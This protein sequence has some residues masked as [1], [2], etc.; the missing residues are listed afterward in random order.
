MKVNFEY[1]HIGGKKMFQSLEYKEYRRKW[2][3][4]PQSFIVE[5]FP[6]FLDIDITNVC[7][8]S[9][10]FCSRQIIKRKCN[11]F[12]SF[13]TVK[14]VIDEGSQN[15]LYG[16]KFNILAEPLMHPELVNFVKY[17]KDKKLIDVYFN[18]N[19]TLLTK[20]ISRKLIKAKLNR[21]SISFEGY[22]KEIYERYR[23]GANFENVVQNIKTLQKEKI[24]LNS[25]VPKV[26]IQTIS[27][28]DVDIEEYKKYW[29]NIVDEV[30][31][32]KYQ[33]RTEEMKHFKSNWICSQLWQRMGIMVD[34][35]IIPC[36]HDENCLS[37]LGNI[38]QT[39]IKE[40]WNSDKLNLIRKQHKNCDAHLLKSC[41]NCYLRQ[42]EII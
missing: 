13:E 42:S 21:I 38:S 41:N 11:K 9:C 25:K 7:N 18:T 17:A 6:L 34:G 12:M 23:V 2:K 36:N 16:V 32:L 10:L 37:S 8:L 28:P 20:N 3:Q 33:P 19:A 22:T 4:N 30:G 29:I 15:N 27:L 35:T 1:Q 40:A 24:K 14:K 39:T 26:R 5:P 31:V